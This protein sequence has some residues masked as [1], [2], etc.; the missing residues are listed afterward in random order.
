MTA[1]QGIRVIE[2]AGLAPV[3]Y[4][5]MLLADFGAEVIRVDRMQST[6]LSSG[7]EDP[8]ARGKRSIRLDLKHPDGV[9]TLLDL[10]DRADVL[11]DSFRPG[12][13]ERLGIGPEQVR[14]RNPRLVYARLTGYGQQGPM[15]SRAGHDINY[16]A[17]SGALALCGRQGQLPAPPANLLA[18]FAAGGLMCAF[19]VL[20]ALLERAHS[21]RGQVIDASM[22]EGAASLTTAIHYLLHVGM[23]KQQRGVNLFDSGAPWYDSYETAD[24]KLVAVGALEPQFYANL[25]AVLEL[26]GELAGSQMDQDAW[27]RMRQRIAERFRTR[28]RSEWM[29]RFDQVDACVTPVLEASELQAH[30]H[31]AAR[32]LFFRAPGGPLQVSAVPRLSRTPGQPAARAPREGE[33]SR[34]LL[35]ELGYDDARIDELINQGAVGTG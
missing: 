30:P 15:A 24:G 9:A 20:L 31:H 5:G 6:L 8:M 10:M 23:W 3:P 35:G 28:T 1:L 2:M 34:E 32:D 21:G 19:G 4:C 12:V 18:D 14:A 11:I 33:H 25:L 16:I 13:M 27:P 29:E 22:V 26:D 17:L 7:P